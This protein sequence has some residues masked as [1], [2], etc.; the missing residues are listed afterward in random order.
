MTAAATSVTCILV[1]RTRYLTRIVLKVEL[2][3]MWQWWYGD[4][5][6]AISE[7]M[8]VFDLSISVYMHCWHCHSIIIIH[9]KEWVKSLSMFSWFIFLKQVQKFIN[10]KSL[11]ITRYSLL[12]AQYYS[13]LGIQTPP[14]KEPIWNLQCTSVARDNI[15]LTQFG[16]KMKFSAI[17]ECSSVPNYEVNEKGKSEAPDILLGQRSNKRYSSRLANRLMCRNV[18]K[19]HPK[20]FYTCPAMQRGQASFWP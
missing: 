10:H 15:K 5:E 1:L 6:H 4:N 11:L 9:G 2:V 3:Y 14:R 17:N 8:A 16:A 19:L 20:P 13:F 7:I 18:I 12:I